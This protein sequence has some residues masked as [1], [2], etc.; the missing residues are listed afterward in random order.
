VIIF[1]D[2]FKIDV[3][4]AR[5]EY[6][7]APGALPVVEYSSIKMDLYRRDFSINTLAINLNPGEFGTLL[8][9]FGATRDL[10][11][12]CLS[13]L[14]NLSFVE[15]PTRAFR[16]IRFEQRFKFRISK[17]T[18]NLIHNAVR[19]NFFDRLSGPRLFHE[20]KLILS[21]ENPIPAIAR[22]AELN[23]L[24]AIHPRLWF[25]EGTRAMLERVQ[26]VLSWF[27][28]L[29]LDEKYEKWLIYFLGADGGQDPVQA[30]P[31]GG[32]AP[33]QPDLSSAFPPGHGI[34]TLHDGQVPP[35]SLQKGHLP[36]FHPPQAPEA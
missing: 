7:E 9:F 21:E 23:L 20:L 1:A 18:L 34:F 17:L 15:D 32:G 12:R 13:V 5:T 16:A 3:A 30:L 25:D 19:N 31:A 2:G 22:L 10:K 24:K 28:L 8:D 27:D 33:P 14:H 11:E 36:L 26:A 35:R 6:Y 29:Y 4:T